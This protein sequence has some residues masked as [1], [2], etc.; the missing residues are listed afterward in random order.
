MDSKTCTT[1]TSYTL[2]SKFAGVFQ[3]LIRSS[4][5]CLYSKVHLEI[6]VFTFSIPFINTLKESSLSVNKPRNLVCAKLIGG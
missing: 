1:V 4:N 3:I 2:R 5:C 6:P